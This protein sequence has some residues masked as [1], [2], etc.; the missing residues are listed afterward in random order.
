MQNY[1][2]LEVF[3]VATMNSSLLRCNVGYF[4]ESPNISGNIASIIR[5]EVYVK[6]EISHLLSVV[7][8][9]AYSLNLKMETVRSSETS[10]TR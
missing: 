10:G 4:G 1:F 5:I 9:F 6:Q 3:S 7:Y 8:R 2:R